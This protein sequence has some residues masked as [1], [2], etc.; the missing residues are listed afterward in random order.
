MK[1]NFLLAAATLLF[2]PLLGQASTDLKEV[3]SSK[4]CM[5]NDTYFGRAQIPVIVSENTY[6]GC[7]ENCKKTLK[8]SQTS[9]QAIDP[10]S[11]KA[12]DKSKAIIGALPDGKVFYFE[13]RSNLKKYKNK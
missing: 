8:T 6:Y 12:V 1:F 11:K 7:C 13:S 10:V 9:R 5:V 2:L 4:V 3:E